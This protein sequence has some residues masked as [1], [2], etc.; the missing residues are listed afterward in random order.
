MKRILVA[1]DRPESLELLR[2][3][4]ESAGY[5]VI[6]AGDGE[7]ALQKAFGDPIDM[8]VLDLQMPKMDG[9]TVLTILRQNRL[10]RDTPI[11]ALTANA[12]RGDRERALAA[13]FTSY[14]TKPVDLAILRSEVERLI[15]SR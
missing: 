4:L 12:M 10:F 3:V 15:E 7:E 6:E 2:T 9:L 11:I 1:E 13:G 14:L 8:V 5:N